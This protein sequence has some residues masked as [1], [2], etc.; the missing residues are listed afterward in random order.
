MQR[1][2]KKEREEVRKRETNKVRVLGIKL[3]LNESNEPTIEKIRV[4]DEIELDNE[5]LKS[6]TIMDC[7]NTL[8]M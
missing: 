8:P 2:G 4:K 6:M 7:V 3:R 1:R 5:Q